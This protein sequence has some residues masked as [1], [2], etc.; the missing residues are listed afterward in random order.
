MKENL[1]Q[2]IQEK[3]IKENQKVNQNR[4]NSI[5]KRNLIQEIEKFKLQKLFK[6][7]QDRNQN[8]RRIKN[9]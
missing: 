4:E 1:F 3:E 6:N 5:I 9:M 7:N 2:K 8:K